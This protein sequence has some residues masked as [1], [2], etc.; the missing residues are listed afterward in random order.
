[1]QG[2]AAALSSK[3]PPGACMIYGIL[4]N[5]TPI[6]GCFSAAEAWSER[7]QD[8]SPTCTTKARSYPAQYGSSSN[9][10]NNGNGNNNHN[11]NNNILG[12]ML[13]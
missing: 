2:S 5:D 11:N 8:N 10:G 3:S 13:I 9:N 1:M 4:D 6:D 7:T 12:T